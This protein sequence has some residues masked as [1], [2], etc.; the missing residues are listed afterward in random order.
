MSAVAHA[1]LP[2]SD[3]RAGRLFGQ[4]HAH[5]DDASGACRH[6]GRHRCIR[7]QDAY[8]ELASAGRI[9]VEPLTGWSPSDLRPPQQTDGA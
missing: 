1:L 8:A 2:I 3:E 7:W 4:L 6:C 5:A 9:E